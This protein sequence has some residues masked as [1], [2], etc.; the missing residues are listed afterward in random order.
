M[1]QYKHFIPE[2][3]APR[4][5]KTIVVCDTNGN[6]VFSIPL[7][8]LTPPS[9][10]PL[11]SFG[12]ASDIHLWT[13]DLEWKGNTKFNNALT[14]FENYGCEFCCV[15]GDLTQ[16]GLYKRTVESDASTTYL[17][18]GQ[19][20]KYKEICD[21]HTI[22]V[23]EISGNH[24]SYYSM[25]ITDNLDRWGTYTGKNVLHYTVDHQNDVFIFCGQSRG[26]DPM[27]DEAFTFLSNTLSA[28]S[29]KRCFVFVHPVWNDDSGD[30]D[31][32]YATSGNGGA[33]LSSWSKGTAL[34]NL[35]KQY[36]K[37]VLFHGHTHI[38][39]EEQE[40]DK[41]L[42]YLKKNGFHSVHIPSLSRPRNV[43]DGALVYAPTESQCYI[44]DV[45]DDCIVLN[46]MDMI[47]NKPVPLGTL[48]IET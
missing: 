26:S 13:S 24:E 18:E 17:D 15:C 6:D 19:L 39:F 2:N 9:G 14:Y 44:V 33:T 29:N 43:I 35:L 47:G 11:Y 12:L 42:N 38:K 30:V 28:N 23:Y 21:K 46:G 34:K 8:R 10:E 45:Y 20:A 40:K 27:T 7:G 48:K 41:T 5:A 1:Y 4:G 32:L 31:G 36:P 16:T 3:I 25:P 37:V 22:P